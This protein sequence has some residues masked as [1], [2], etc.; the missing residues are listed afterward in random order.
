MSAHHWMIYTSQKNCMRQAV[1]IRIFTPQI[2]KYITYCT[3]CTADTWNSIFKW[4]Q[5]IGKGFCLAYACHSCWVRASIRALSLTLR[6]PRN[7]WC[8]SHPENRTISYQCYQCWWRAEWWQL[9]SIKKPFRPG[10]FDI[11]VLTEHK[12]QHLLCTQTNTPNEFLEEYVT[13]VHRDLSTKERI[14]ALRKMR[15]TEHNAKNCLDWVL[16]IPGMFHFKMACTNAFWWIHVL[17]ALGCGNPAG[18]FEYIHHLHPWET[19]KFVSKP[20]FQ[21]MHDTIHHTTWADILDCWQLAA[22][23]YG[24]TLLEDFAASQP[25]WNTVRNT[26][27]I[28]NYMHIFN[29]PFNI[30]ISPFLTDVLYQRYV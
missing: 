9:G 15:V 5:H 17:P 12:H 26:V 20:G 4:A 16:F 25:E 22:E 7:C 28:S 6:P 10:E 30:P 21:Q 14:D 3:W 27:T 1:S 11:H 24:F 13:L 8:T 18:F 2:Q 23:Q 29:F 19:G